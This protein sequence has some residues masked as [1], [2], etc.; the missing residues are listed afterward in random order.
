MNTLQNGST[1]GEVTMLQRALSVLG[2]T[3][4]IDGDY[5]PGTAAVVTQFQTDKGLTANG[6]A[7]PDTWSIIDSLAPQGM[8]I[9]HNNDAI[10]W[11]DLT[12]HIQFVYC[13]YSESA[14]FNDREFDT[15]IAKI[16]QKSLMMGAYH[17]F[18]FQSPAQDQASNFL[19]CGLDFSDKAN[20]LPPMID[21][22]TESDYLRDNKDACVQSITDWIS[23]VSTQTGR[24][25]VIYTFKWFWNEY[26]AGTPQFGSNPL[27]I[28]A[29]QPQSPG[30]PPEWDK[31]TI[32]QYSQN[33][34]LPGTSGDVDQDIFNGT[35]A[36]L[37]SL[38]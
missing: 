13:K 32:W 34:P 1:G 10:N 36:Q 24:T 15:Y 8:D 23:A 14:G 11:D 16:K 20:V 35:L 18:D 7:A 26:L 4:G 19:A 33:G 25:P 27:W 21:L 30:I 28:S 31:Y 6:V 3:I 37:K 5:G 38:A 17:F 22:E 9:S 29:F 2:Y 12:P